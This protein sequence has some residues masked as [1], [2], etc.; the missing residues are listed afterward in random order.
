VPASTAFFCLF[1]LLALCRWRY[2]GKPEC[3]VTFEGHVDWVNDVL[4]YK[5]R[6]VTCSSDR[7]VKIW[8]ADE[9]G[10]LCSRVFPSCGC[11]SGCAAQGQSWAQSAAG[12]NCDP[13]RS[14]S[15][16]PAAVNPSCLLCCLTPPQLFLPPP[17]PPFPPPWCSSPLGGL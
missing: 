9:Q 17:P 1:L 7:S 10:G 3:D 4:V 15:T 2:A 8:Q 6:L 16:L 13:Q 12:S 14:P 5:D 11:S